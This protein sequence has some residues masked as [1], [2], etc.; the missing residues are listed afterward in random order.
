MVNQ[1][2]SRYGLI[3]FCLL[4]S[5]CGATASDPARSHERYTLFFQADPPV[6]E[7]APLKVRVLQLKS[8]AAFMAA[9]FY[10]LQ[11]QARAV[12]GDDL[13]ASDAFFLLPDQREKTVSGE[14]APQAGYLGI[15]AEYQT[16]DG[17]KWRLTVPLPDTQKRHRW[18]LW[19]TSSGAG[20][21][22][23][24]LDAHGIRLSDA[25]Q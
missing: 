1:L 23:L 24:R 17:K 3:L 6:N 11:N 15:M 19:K 25:G 18:A 2:L 14:R 10:S 22:R 13:V 7:A 8:T 4:L 9:D 12:L 5:G 21:A 16:L 20:D